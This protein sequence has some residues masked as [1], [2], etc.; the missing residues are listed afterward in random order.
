MAC[1]D[2]IGPTR[3]LSN[4][5]YQLQCYIISLMLN[6]LSKYAA[7]SYYLLDHEVQLGLKNRI[8]GTVDAGMFKGKLKNRL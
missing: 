4:Y 7:A 5:S 1:Y 6:A 8:L 2:I 3:L